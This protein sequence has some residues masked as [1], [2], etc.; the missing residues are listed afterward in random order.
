MRLRKDCREATARGRCRLSRDTG[1]AQALATASCLPVQSALDLPDLQPAREG[2][3]QRGDYSSQRRADTE[4][5]GCDTEAAPA[6]A[7]AS[8]LPVRSPLG[9]LDLQ[10]AHVR[11]V[12]QGESSSQDCAGHAESLPERWTLGHDTGQCRLPQLRHAC[13]CCQRWAGQILCLHIESPAVQ[14]Q[15]CCTATGSNCR[16]HLKVPSK[17]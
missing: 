8:C 12:Q 17:A 16:G 11:Q 14:L 7:A 13:Q 9:R 15:Q 5:N 1:A 2:Q 6:L 4:D 3:A 10:P